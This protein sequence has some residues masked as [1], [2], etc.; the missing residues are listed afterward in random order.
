VK[1]LAILLSIALL[2]SLGPRSGQAATTT[3]WNVGGSVAF[4]LMQ[5][6]LSGPGGRS[7]SRL[8]K[9]SYLALHATGTYS[10]LPWL[11]AGA[12]ALVERGWRTA[13]DY[14]GVDASQV[15]LTKNA[16]GGAYTLFWTGPLVRARWSLLFFEAGYV[17]FGV[18][19]DPWRSNLPS[20]GGDSSSV[21]RTGTPNRF[22]LGLG[23]RIPLS[24]AIEL[25]LR[26]EYRYHYYASRGGDALEND[27]ELGSQALRPH[28]G[29]SYSF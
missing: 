9:D 4:A 7:S 21:F 22:L 26:I 24:S 12:F 1:R 15:P 27:V 14:A 17:L 28:L 19:S 23:A 10:A 5:E 6:G 2:A 8:F 18:K 13:A 3:P 16:L 25:L 29:A 20:K 11:D